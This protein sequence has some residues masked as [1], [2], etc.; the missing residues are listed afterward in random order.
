MVVGNGMIAKR[1]AVYNNDNT[2]LIY[3]SGVSNSKNQN[4]SEYEREINL[5][6]KNIAENKEKHLVY[7]STCGVY[8]PSEKNSL[9]VLHKLKIEEII[10]KEA[11]NYNIFRAS[12]LMGYSN[13]PNTIINY[14]LHHIKGDINFDVWQNAYRNIIDLDD[15]FTIT[16]HI[17]SNHIHP[18]TTINIANPQQYNTVQIVH[19]IENLL[20]K[21][22]NY[23]LIERGTEFK[24]DTS[25]IHPIIDQLQINFDENYLP[26]ILK[27]YFST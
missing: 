2:Y 12:N 23:S 3:A 24:I 16:H 25:V 4:I 21:K 27:K 22:A 19:A 26:A 17:L 9:Y 14:Y 18:N 5:L 15:V 20:Q 7:F 13:N 10:K 6:Q 8:D 11:V 1:F